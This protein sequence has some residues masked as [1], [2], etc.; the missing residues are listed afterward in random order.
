MSASGDR[1]RELF[2]RRRGFS[3]LE[4][5]FAATISVV[6]LAMSFVAMRP[7][8]EQEGPQGLAF[9]LAAD[10]RA[11]RAEAIRSG[12]PVAV[13][14]A[15]ESRTNSLTRSARVRVGEQKGKVWRTLSYDSEFEATI[16]LGKWGEAVAERFNI[17]NG[18]RTSTARETALYFGPDGSAYS[19]DILVLEGRYPLLV[20]SALEGTFNGPEGTVSAARHPQTV[21]VSQRGT[22]EVLPG[23]V[24][25]GTLPSTNRAELPVALLRD[26]VTPTGLS[27][28]ILSSSFLP[29]QIEGLATAGI[30]QNFVQIHPNQKDG[31][32]LEYGL[33]TIAVRAEDI[34]GGP[35]RYTL[36]ATASSGEPGKFSVSQ[37]SGD[38]SFIYDEVE[39]R[40]LWSTVVSWRPP[41]SAPAGLTYELTLTV[42][43]PEGN[44]AEVSTAAGLLPAVTSL[45]PARLVI[46]SDAREMYLANLDGANEVLL[47]QNGQ[48]YSPFFS[49]DGSCVF[50]FHDVDS[51]GNRELR[52]RPSNGSVGYARLASFR[53]STSNVVYD[54]TYTFVAITNPNGFHDFDFSVKTEEDDDD[55]DDDDDDSGGGDSGGSPTLTPG[56]TAVAVSNVYV[57]NLMSTDPPILVTSKGEGDF[58][59]AANARHT[60]YYS[61]NVPLP[62]IDDPEVGPYIPPP[63]YEVVRRAKYLVGFPPAVVDSDVEAVSAAGRVYNPANRDWYLMVQ[64]SRLRMFQE[65]TGTSFTLFDAPGGI[66]HSDWGRDNPSWSADGERVVFVASPGGSARVISMRVLDSSFTALSSP[67]INFDLAT[68]NPKKAQLSPGGEWVYFLSG[69]NLMRADNRTGS[70]TV[71]ISDHLEREITDYVVSP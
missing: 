23:E 32:Q 50:S 38:L 3:L 70:P 17:P 8:I 9:A 37:Q 56:S 30:G 2:F 25:L 64:G 55:D 36:S 42:H 35:L 18:W 47:T 6:L 51:A 46:C 28:T 1:T 10:L 21:W 60:F 13:C 11:A 68:S 65:T 34:D 39:R 7:T 26:D 54:P 43:D 12:R 53:G 48:E 16:F 52:S 63:G 4:L 61:D 69:G 59:W 5:I 19:E 27:P 22:I 57:L 71:D 45:P 40:H 49:Q 24:P 33:A 58:Y 41:P 62:T 66:E 29:E 14:F 20:A 15:S 44:T 31:Q 67:Q